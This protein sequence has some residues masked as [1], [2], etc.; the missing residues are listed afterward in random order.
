MKRKLLFAICLLCMTVSFHSCEL[1]NCKVC[2]QNTY[3]QNNNLINEGSES[4]YCGAS[5][6]RVEATPPTTVLGV[7]TKWECR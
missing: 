1:E 5:L 4:E 2:Q 6:L 7:T 3:D